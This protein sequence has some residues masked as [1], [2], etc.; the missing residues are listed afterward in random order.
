[1]QYLS[2]IPDPDKW[3]NGVLGLKPSMSKGMSLVEL[4]MENGINTILSAYP[5][6]RRIA[7]EC[8]Y[9]LKCFVMELCTFISEAFQNWKTRGHQG[10]MT[11]RMHGK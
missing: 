4:Q 11:K 3:D 9:K 7:Q 10:A 2:A 1:M 8:L 5:E 6:A